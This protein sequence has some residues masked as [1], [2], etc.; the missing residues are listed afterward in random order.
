METASTLGMPAP[1]SRQACIRIQAIH[2]VAQ[3]L[4]DRQRHTRNV[5]DDD[6]VMYLT[7]FPGPPSFP[8]NLAPEASTK[9]RKQTFMPEA[10]K[11]CIWQVK[12][13]GPKPRLKELD[14][15]GAFSMQPSVNSKDPL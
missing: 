10:R 5:V 7:H 3:G 14:S 15:N 9:S 13:T 11:P 2:G 12:F 6:V 4:Y 8:V 1:T